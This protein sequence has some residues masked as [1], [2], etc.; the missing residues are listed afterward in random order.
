MLNTRSDYLVAVVPTYNRL[1]RLKTCLDSIAAE[2]RCSHEVVVVDGGSTDGTIEY[3]K[4]HP[5][6]TP[7][8]QRELL[9]PTRAF[10]SAWRRIE[11]KYTCYLNDDLVVVEGSLAMAVRILEMHPEIGM[12][13]LKTKDVQGP[14]AG[15]AYIGGISRY[16]ILTCNFGV[17][18]TDLLRSVGYFSEEYRMYA[19]DADLTAKILC[20]GKSVAM[21]KRISLLHY[22]DISVSSDEEEKKRREQ[23]M[24]EGFQVYGNKFQFLENLSRGYLWKR[25]LGSR[26]GRILFLGAKSDTKRLGMCLRDFHNIISGRFIKLTDPIEHI[27]D[28]FHLVQ[29]IPHSLL[30]QESNPYRLES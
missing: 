4:S 28:E 21:T 19:A 24:I 11:S 17:L 18:R 23:W 25:R 12:V 5:A 22:K 29:K 8:F 2:T 9:G 20:T 27:N 13:G 26:L 30:S 1:N 3:L 16:G 15:A 10:N 6:V 7:V 14:G